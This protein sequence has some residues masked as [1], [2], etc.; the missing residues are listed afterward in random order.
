LGI[1]RR[2]RAAH[3]V[4][5]DEGDGTG[6]TCGAAAIFIGAAGSRLS[7]ERLHLQRRGAAQ[8]A[9]HGSRWHEPNGNPLTASRSGGDGLDVPRASSCSATGAAPR[10]A[11]RHDF[12]GVRVRATPV[13]SPRSLVVSRAED[14]AEQEADRLAD[15]MIGA[16]VPHGRPTATLGA[17]PAGDSPKQAEICIG[18]AGGQP[19]PES[20]QAYFEPRLGRDL[21]AVR[22]H[23]GPETAGSAGALGALAYTVGRDVVFAAGQYAPNA[24]AG[25]RLLAHE[26]A[27]VVRSTEPV[28]CPPSRPRRQPS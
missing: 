6:G 22:I 11:L 28:S 24:A 2:D 23:T 3:G 26:L 25:R 17:W 9:P 15:E 5:N 19:L 14:A 13:P 27:H 12:G 1:T 21:S 10:Q 18:L 7:C 20:V 4:W 8:V 16:P